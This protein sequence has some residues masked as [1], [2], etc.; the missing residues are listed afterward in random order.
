MTLRQIINNRWL[1]DEEKIIELLYEA[2]KRYSE[3]VKQEKF[4]FY[5]L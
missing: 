5:F 3:A 2:N 4:W 1:N